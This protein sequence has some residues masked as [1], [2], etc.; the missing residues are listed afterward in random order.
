M[1]VRSG[2]M[3]SSLLC[4]IGIEQGRSG[5]SA[6][7]AKTQHHPNMAL[8][9]ECIKN[10]TLQKKFAKYS[11]SAPFFAII[12]IKEFAIFP[13]S[14]PESCLPPPHCSKYFNETF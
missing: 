3:A 12:V 2:N 6:A 14:I 4:S 7:R 13:R 9:I 8:V 10:I 1:D 11:T 5:S